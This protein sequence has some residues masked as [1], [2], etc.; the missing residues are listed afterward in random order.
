[1]VVDFL[2]LLRAQRVVDLLSNFEFE[3]DGNVR[4]GSR[5][6]DRISSRVVFTGWPTGRILFLPTLNDNIPKTGTP[7]VIAIGLSG[8]K[9]SLLA[10]IEPQTRPDVSRLGTRAAPVMKP[11]ANP[12][13]RTM[14]IKGTG[15]RSS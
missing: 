12:L 1:M 11:R 2:L 6:L 7:S 9:L 14:N 13:K 5:R 15:C 3:V 8:G 4:T 10:L